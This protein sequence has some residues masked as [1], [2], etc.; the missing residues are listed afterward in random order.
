MTFSPI[1]LGNQ[2]AAVARNIAETIESMEEK[3][4]VL[5]SSEIGDNLE[6]AKNMI[7]KIKDIAGEYIP[8]SFLRYHPD[9]KLSIP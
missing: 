9:Y 1:I 5:I 3:P 6:E 8:L 4:F 2:G 7:Q